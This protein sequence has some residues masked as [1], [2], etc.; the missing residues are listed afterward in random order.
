[1]IFLSIEIEFFGAH[2]SISLSLSFFSTEFFLQ[3]T[4]E[5]AKL[6]KLKIFIPEKA[7]DD[8]KRKKVFRKI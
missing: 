7:K 8:F 1:M 3:C 6:T 2:K 5:D 4:R